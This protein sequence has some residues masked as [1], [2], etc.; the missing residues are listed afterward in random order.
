MGIVQS[1]EWGWNDSRTIISIVGG[2]A[3]LILFLRRSAQ[4]KSPALDLKLFHDPN[5]RFANL[6]TLF[7]D[8]NYRFA[9]LATLVFGM[10][11]NAMFFGLV[12]FLTKVWGYS[13]LAAG[14]AITPGPLMVALVTPFAGRIA[15]ARGHRVLIVPGG[16]IFAMGSLLLYTQA[17]VTPS[18][19][20]TW[21]PSAILIGIGVGLLLSILS[22][23]AVHSIPPN[24]F[25]VGSAI[26]QA[27]RQI[28]SVLGIA[29][30]IA[31]LGRPSPGELLSAFDRIFAFLIAGG[32][33]TSLI[34]MNIKTQ[35]TE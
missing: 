9:N 18:F 24:R 13:T 27:I 29:I 23:A 17:Q 20:A 2:I 19:F 5:Y 12:L 26:N 25:A 33:L 34:G 32:L 14:L 10:A 1:D 3:L 6:A 4:V 21:L 15:D 16:I 7:H 31:L 30:V 35:S 11:F 22:S 28:G 8:P